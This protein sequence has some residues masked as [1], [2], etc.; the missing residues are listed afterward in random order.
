MDVRFSSAV[1]NS[2]IYEKVEHIK[3]IFE[4]QMRQ[5]TKNS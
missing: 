3:C 4:K 2:M 1:G 5:K